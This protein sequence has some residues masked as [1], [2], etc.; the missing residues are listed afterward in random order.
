[1]SLND[2][3]NNFHRGDIKKEATKPNKHKEK[4]GENDIHTT[5]ERKEEKQKYLWCRRIYTSSAN[6][7]GDW[8]RRERK[9]TPTIFQKH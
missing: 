4:R 6:G 8:K 5:T 7:D 2:F 1:M 9:N 3:I